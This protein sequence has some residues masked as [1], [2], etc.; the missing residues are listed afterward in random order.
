M[1]HPGAKGVLCR[2]HSGH[3]GRGT[4]NPGDV[5]GN[6]PGAGADGAGGGERVQSLGRRH[7]GA[8]RGG[9]AGPSLVQEEG[10]PPCHF[11]PHGEAA[12]WREIL[13]RYFTHCGPATLR[14]AA[15]FLGLSQRE[16][17]R[18]M[19]DLDL[20]EIP[21]GGGCTMILGPAGVCPIFRHACSWRALIR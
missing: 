8:G 5:A 17:K 11:E 2:P 15:Y 16:L 10:L 7:P 4:G 21:C 9:E 12:A 19:Q 14:D 1:D 20:R 13:R 18:Q 3:A 6:L